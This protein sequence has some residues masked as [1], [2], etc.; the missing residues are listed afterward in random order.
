MLLKQSS[1]DLPT[2]NLTPMLDVVFNLMVFFMVGT[3]FT[4]LDHQIKVDV[5]KVSQ[6]GPLTS[7]PSKRIVSITREGTLWLDGRE[8]TL[9]EITTELARARSEFPDLGVVVK[10]DGKGEFQKVADA[11]AAVAQAGVAQTSICVR[12]EDVSTKTRR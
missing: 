3:K 7:P 12:I 4:E 2:V 11:L 9:P 6:A 8:T 1:D 10:G 5:P